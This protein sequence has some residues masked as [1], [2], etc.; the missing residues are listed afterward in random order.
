MNS[1]KKYRTAS[2]IPYGPYIE[3]LPYLSRRLY[4]NIDIMKYSIL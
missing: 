1:I 4:E 2:Y 3:M